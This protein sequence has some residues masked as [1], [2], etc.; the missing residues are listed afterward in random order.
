MAVY[1]LLQALICSTILKLRNL[2]SPLNLGVFMIGCAI[3][4]MASFFL[5]AMLAMANPITSDPGTSALNAMRYSFMGLVFAG[6][7]LG[8]L[9]A[10]NL[11]LKWF[12]SR[13]SEA[14]DTGLSPTDDR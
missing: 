6:G 10:V 3:G 12:T 1:F 14:E 5:M 8:G 2:L 9:L 7:Q 11:R 13:P 4:S